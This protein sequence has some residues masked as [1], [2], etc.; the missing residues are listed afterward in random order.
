[1]FKKHDVTG[2]TKYNLLVECNLSLLHKTKCA[3]N[4]DIFLRF[5]FE[6]L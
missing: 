6:L 2:V 1:M 3:D 5:K 4:N